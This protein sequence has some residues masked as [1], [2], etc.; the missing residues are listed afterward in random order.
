M[1]KKR[2]GIRSVESNTEPDLVV[3]V[4]LRSE[5]ISRKVVSVASL[6][7]FVQTPARF[8]VCRGGVWVGLVGCG[9]EG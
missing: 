4:G 7:R 1:K 9:V 8:Y 6:A 3:A 2:K 5:Y